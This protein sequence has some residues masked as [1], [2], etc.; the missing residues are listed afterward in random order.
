MTEE[1]KKRFFV[2]KMMFIL[3]LV[4]GLGIYFTWVFIAVAY[5]D[6]SLWNALTDVGL[7]AITIVI[8]LFGLFGL[9]L[10]RAREKEALDE[11]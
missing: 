1:A 10:Y 3:L 7:Y 11:E 2:G 6:V 9:L 4:L 8:V 5:G